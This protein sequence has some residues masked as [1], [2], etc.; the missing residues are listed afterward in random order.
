MDPT[1]VLKSLWRYR[2]YVL[3]AV[4]ITIGVALYVFMLGPRAYESTISYAL[5]NPDVPTEA[6]IE[7]DP[8][9]AQLN[10]DNPYLRSTDPNLVAN[11]VITR[12]NAPATGE[13][14]EDVG[15]SSDYEVS[16]GVGGSG[17]IVQIT[18]VGS[19]RA[20]SLATSR[21]LGE[22][23][24]SELQTIQTVNG[25]DERFLFTSIV[26]AQPDRATE[27]FASRL[28]SVIVVLI[29]GVILVFG[30]VS[31]GRGVDAVRARRALQAAAAAAPGSRVDD[32]EPGD[33]ELPRIG[34]KRAG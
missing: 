12:L 34:R 15:L 8:G 24:E 6:D 13:Y 30:A 32:P 18:G 4:L 23:F 20:Q 16:P 29:G 3:P 19:S 33:D 26:V 21:T 28:R 5:V 11:V 2:W 17:F 1:A 10:G 31:I 22:M 27:Q 9:L 14:L 25:A 7:R